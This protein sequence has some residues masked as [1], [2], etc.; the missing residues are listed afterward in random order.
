MDLLFNPWVISIVV[1]CVIVGNIAALK[2][3]SQIK[4]EEFMKKKDLDRLN[5]LDKERHDEHQTESVNSE[6]KTHEQLNNDETS[7]RN[8]Q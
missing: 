1:I 6:Q 3:T 4:Y 5:Q 8:K 2:Y 7:S